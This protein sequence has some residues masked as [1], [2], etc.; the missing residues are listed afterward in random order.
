[1]ANIA[2]D[3]F[4]GTSGDALSTYD[5]N[6]TA[7][8]GTTGDG[9]ISDAGRVRGA[10]TAAVARYRA[11]VTPSSAD[12]SVSCDLYIASTLSN[13]AGVC[14]R[15]DP[16]ANTRYFARYNRSTAGVEL[17]KTVSGTST[18]LGSTSSQTASAGSTYRLELIVNGTTIA[19][20]WDGGGSPVISQTDSAISNAGHPGIIFLNPSV[21]GNTSGIHIDNW[22]VDTL[23]AALPT[24][25][26]PTYK[27]GTLTSGGFTPR[28]TAS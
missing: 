3:A 15:Q 19:A 6:W 9:T 12:Y 7:S 13:R 16:S 14:A 5:A 26:S 22:S 2:S 27:P 20:Y 4:G 21:A 11:D 10:T 18:Q 28:V 17:I 1:M 25:S 24:L 8:S 23:G